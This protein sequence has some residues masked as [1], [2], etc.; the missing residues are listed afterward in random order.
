M[1]YRDTLVTCATCGKEFIFRVEDQRKQSERGEDVAPPASCPACRGVTSPEHAT[2]TRSTE[3]RPEPKRETAPRSKAEK[4]DA[5]IALGPGPHEGIVKWFDGEKGYGFLAHPDGAEIFFH[6][7][8]IAPGEGMDFP[9]GAPVTFLIEQSE[10]GPQAVD[11]ARM[12]EGAEEDD[13]E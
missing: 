6:R 9:D 7:S 4:V 2:E 3:R 13:E 5:T 10:K 8:G 11:V 12:D 1:P